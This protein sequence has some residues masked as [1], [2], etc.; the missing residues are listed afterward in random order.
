MADNN[1][2]DVPGGNDVASILLRAA[3]IGASDVHLTIGEPPC[4]R[5]DG[6]IKP[7]S[8]SVLT[9]ESIHHMIYD[10]L[11]DDKRHSFEENKELDFSFQLGNLGR[12]RAN[13]FYT[14]KG[15]GAAFRVIPSDIKG[16]D[17]LGL[18]PVTMKISSR[19]RGL[20]LVTGPTGSGK[21]TTL[22]AMID[23]VNKNRDDHIITIEDPI[24]FVHK[25]KRCI[26][27]Q[28]EVGSD[29]RTFSN[30]LRS[31]LRED[32]DVILVG[33]LRDLETI[34][35]ALTAA[36]TGHLV[37][38]TM[39][40]QSAA[41]TIDRLVDVFPAE[42]QKLVRVMFADSFEAILC[43]SLLPRIDKPGR[44]LALEILLATPSTRS[45]MREGKSHQINTIIQTGQKLGMMSLD[46]CLKDLAMRGI[47]SEFHAL[48]RASNPDAV[49]TNGVQRLEQYLAREAMGETVAASNNPVQQIPQQGQQP[50]QQQQHQQQ[51]PSPPPP[52]HMNQPATPHPPQQGRPAPPPP[53]G[54]QPLQK[55]GPPPVPPQSPPQQH[56][57]QQ[58]GV[59][60][61]PPLPSQRPAP[62]P[63]G[64]PGGNRPA[65]PPPRHGSS[66]S[67][68]FSKPIPPMPEQEAAH[69]KKDNQKNDQSGKNDERE[70]KVD[71]PF[72]PKK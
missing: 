41:K 39:H 22:A 36:E 70:T 31:A 1:S 66:Q 48:T 37:F 4:M 18:P 38:G 47:I 19:P 53:P 27:N 43:Q 58:Q 40:T 69:P 63:P 9:K 42:Q 26:V 6:I 45:L 14:M 2:I 3:E 12:F 44:V 29:T 67:Q 62:P 34:S 10:I 8:M 46:M 32:P 5:V 64:P 25:N 24:E 11:D 71:F 57:G 60:N 16:F 65:P 49:V 15:E 54:Q 33:E 17:E 51:R 23:F 72:G 21:S 35:L 30:A 28:R 68:V 59:R 7:T 56:Q 20:I 52:P 61:T 50:P 55:P 13:Y